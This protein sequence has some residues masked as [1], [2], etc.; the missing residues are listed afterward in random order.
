[1]AT[2]QLVRS[3][4]EAG[5][6][7][8]RALDEVAFGVVAALWLYS[9]EAGKWRFVVATRDDRRNIEKKYL[10]AAVAASKWK[11]KH[12]DRPILDLSRVRIVGR[13]DPL[14]KGLAVFLHVEG[15]GEMRF[16]NNMVNGVY[17]E[18][19]LIHRLAA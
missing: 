8:I 11:E 1:M 19:A 4:I 3:E 6:Q 14:I 15:L 2:E 16:S 5:L 9:S 18:D 10:E 17:V 7:L 13:E 12:P